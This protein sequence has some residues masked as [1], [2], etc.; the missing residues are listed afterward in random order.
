MRNVKQEHIEMFNKLKKDFP[1]IEHQLDEIELQFCDKIYE[2]VNYLFKNCDNFTYDN[3]QDMFFKYRDVSIMKLAML[4]TGKCPD[5]IAENLIFNSPF[6]LSSKTP[7][8]NF[9]DIDTAIV[10]EVLRFNL[11]KSTLYDI[12][13]LEPSHFLFKAY[14]SQGK[15]VVSNMSQSSINA[16]CEFV[17]DNI[18]LFDCNSTI[19]TFELEHLFEDLADKEFLLYLL[20]KMGQSPEYEKIRSFC[21]NNQTLSLDN[22]EDV[23][24]MDELFDSANLR[25]INVYT[26]KT[27]DYIA[28]HVANIDDM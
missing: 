13:K 16:F 19:S 14:H 8:F 25:Y 12:F 20:D 6:L 2:I 9:D 5:E 10:D 27:I 26:P 15:T 23:E 17:V 3:W 28:K 1:N 7:N 4:K 21:I 22:K 11:S 18:H 24:L